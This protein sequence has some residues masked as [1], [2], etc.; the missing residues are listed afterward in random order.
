MIFL[1]AL[2]FGVLVLVVYSVLVISGRLSDEEERR[3]GKG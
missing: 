2:A 3:N 1:G